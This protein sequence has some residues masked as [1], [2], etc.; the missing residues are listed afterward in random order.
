M[1]IQVKD[2]NG[3]PVA[4]AVVNVHTSESLVSR[5]GITDDKGLLTF[6]WF[7]SIN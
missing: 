4:G 2:L 5:K 7:R 3:N 1:K 6:I